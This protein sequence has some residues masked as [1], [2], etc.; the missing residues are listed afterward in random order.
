[1]LI[2]FSLTLFVSAALLF[3][4][5]PM[6]AKLVLPL[7]GS[8]PGV[9]TASVMVFQALL[10]GGYVYAHATTGRIGVRRQAA[11]HVI[12]MVLAL[13]AL[14]I[15]LPGGWSPPV[16]ANPVVW[17]V[18]LLLVA[19][20]LPF[21]VISASA[22]LLQRWIAAT[23]H[24][25]AADP[26][27]LYR[28][29]NLG[30]MVGLLGYPLAMEPTLALA[31]QGRLW[32]A[33][34][35]LLLV[36]VLACVVMLWRSR[37]AAEA[38]PAIAGA[39]GEAALLPGRG[40]ARTDVIRRLR[41]VALSFV[42][43]SLVLGVTTYFTTDLAPI[44]LL[45]V[46]PLALY[47]LTFIVVFSPRAEMESIHRG[48]VAVFPIMVL[49]VV[50]TIVARVREPLG[51][52]VALHLAGFFVAAMVCH[53]E[54]ARDRPEPARLTEF[55]LWV[56][57]GGVL[58]GAFNALVAPVAFNGLLEYP[59]AIVL[60]CLLRPRLTRALRSRRDRVLDLALP[61]ALA[62][63]ATA[64]LV[65]VQSGD[66]FSAAAGGL[67]VIVL[68]LALCLYFARDPTRF[69]LGVAALL[70]AG[71]WAIGSA[72]SVLYRER[73]FFGIYEVRTGEELPAR[74]RLIHGTTL[75]GAQTFDGSQ[76]PAP[77]TYYHPT[78]PIGQLF[79]GPASGR[80]SSRVAVLGLGAG[81]IACHARPRD[82]W[83][84][85][86]IDPT[87][88]RI[89]RD[90]RLFTYLRDC[91]ARSDVVLGDGRLSIARAR[92]GEFG[93][94]FADAFSSDAI[95]VHL[96]TREAV[97]VYLS[98]LRPEGL[99]IFNVTN[100]YLDL[101]PVLGALAQERGLACVAASDSATE[102]ADRKGKTASA[103]V[104]MARAQRHLGALV[105]DSRWQGCRRA[106]PGDV[107]TDDFSNILGPWRR[108]SKARARRLLPSS[109]L[110]AV[111]PAAGQVTVFPFTSVQPP[112]AAIPPAVS[113]TV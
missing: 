65:L 33:G 109:T 53:G 7:L 59:I 83:T 17:L 102:G 43:S 30:S 74:N 77:S 58:G 79:E 99:L 73:S 84:F 47:L 89:A 22:P 21:F 71:G 110:T 64:L 29:S 26:Y 5:Q 75:H 38:L 24:P 90:P 104:V 100:R 19:V 101:N 3:L 113:A 69:G 13:V 57:V 108:G 12:V 2:V 96:L 44:P 4:V 66:Q 78:G 49:L 11:L 85:Y 34:Y 6:F 81:T 67:G 93:L 46:V 76:P 45:W 63:G 1:M 91:P 52:L 50:F 42:P 20:G 31:D 18:G 92:P 103:W 14:P 54:L 35:G 72:D 62:V 40:L 86:E 51:P 16:D 94:I 28:A 48:M 70:V 111:T 60:A 56:A 87:A 15:A 106:A 25:A 112:P 37:P 36:L 8:T 39:S 55:Y 32:A 10:L 98:K 61:V 107:W 23:D 105:G 95:P 97:A 41:W 9:W 88:E 80:L 68:S 82:R 27:L